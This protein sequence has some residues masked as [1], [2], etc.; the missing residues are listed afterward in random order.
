MKEVEIRKLNESVAL[1]NSYLCALNILL[2][3]AAGALIV[4][5]FLHG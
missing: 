3:M 1:A 2:G 4:Y 5:M